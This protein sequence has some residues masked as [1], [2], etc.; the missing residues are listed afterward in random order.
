MPE[1]KIG[2]YHTYKF[3]ED[4]YVK[5]RTSVLLRALEGEAAGRP[6]KWDFFNGEDR[7]ELV[8]RSL[9]QC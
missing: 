3:D 7:D 1:D 9:R 5:Y 8:R 6:M 4:M 2:L